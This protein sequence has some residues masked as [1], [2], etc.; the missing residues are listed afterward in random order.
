MRKFLRKHIRTV[1]FAAILSVLCSTMVAGFMALV[2]QSYLQE[3]VPPDGKRVLLPV[4][5][6]FFAA[7]ILWLF[8]QNGKMFRSGICFA[9][10]S[11]LAGIPAFV[12]LSI[13]EKSAAFFS[14]YFIYAAVVLVCTSFAVGLHGLSKLTSK[15]RSK[16]HLR[17]FTEN[18]G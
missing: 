7:T 16:R 13:F 1:Q 9:V 6:V 12:L 5:L 17:H 2:M 18:Q 8:W 11:M 10:V 3:K 15:I 14:I 4:L